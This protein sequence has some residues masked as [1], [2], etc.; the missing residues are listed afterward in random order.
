MQSVEDF[1]FDEN[2]AD[3][4]PDMIQ[5]SIPGYL[6]IL[7]TIGDLA[8]D[9]VTD[10]SNVYDLGCSLGAASMAIARN[11]GHCHCNIIGIDSSQAMVERCQRKVQSFSLPNPVV[12]SC[13]KAQDVQIEKASMVVMNFTLQFIPP[14]DRVELLRKIYQGLNAGGIL[15]LSEK[16]QHETSRG[17]E[18]LI[19]LHHKFK[20][21][22]GYSEL[23]VSQK[24]AALE[25][26]MLTDTF[27]THEKRL[28]DAGFDTVVRWFQCYNFTSMVAVKSK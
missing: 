11:T 8:A 4:F 26:V 20:R 13:Q 18:L 22:N 19:D 17:N 23:E 9:F 14:N 24:R 27:E 10:E 21:E 6:S 16:I 3:V 7:Q 2:V 15:V 5:R 28:K 12:V 1:R 25:N